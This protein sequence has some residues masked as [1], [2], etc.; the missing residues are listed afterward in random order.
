VFLPQSTTSYITCGICDNS[1]NSTYTVTIKKNH[2]HFDG[3]YGHT[4]IVYTV[5][6]SAVLRYATVVKF[7]L[8]GE[9]ALSFLMLSCCV[10]ARMY[11]YTYIHICTH[12]I[13]W[14]VLEN[15]VLCNNEQ[16]HYFQGQPMVL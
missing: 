8:V 2:F 6:Y 10:C 13:F 5:L 4:R 9:Y 7:H 16:I 12:Y 11:I 14:N 1:L 15:K 3:R